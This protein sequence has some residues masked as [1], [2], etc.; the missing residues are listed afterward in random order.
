[1]Q[2][3]GGL[4]CPGA[5]KKVLSN[6]STEHNA[7]RAAVAQQQRSQRPAVAYGTAKFVGEGAQ[8]TLSPDLYTYIY[9]YINFLTSS[10]ATHTQQREFHPRSIPQVKLI[11]LS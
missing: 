9:I 8:A 10:V 5:Q 6:V 4:T 11:L 3:P 2:N 1:M 7:R